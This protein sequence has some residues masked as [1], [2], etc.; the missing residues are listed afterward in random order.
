MVLGHSDIRHGFKVVLQVDLAHLRVCVVIEDAEETGGFGWLIGVDVGVSDAF[1]FS[2]DCVTVVAASFYGVID[3][4]IIWSRVF[5]HH[6]S[7]MG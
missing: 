4:H 7:G 3:S 1:E 2:Q 6:L 5:E